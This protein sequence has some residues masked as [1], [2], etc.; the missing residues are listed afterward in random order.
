MGQPEIQATTT[1][2]FSL[3]RLDEQH[4]DDFALDVRRGLTASPKTLPPKYFYDD[5]GSVLFEGICRL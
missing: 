4:D 3:V 2:S 5:L 1:G